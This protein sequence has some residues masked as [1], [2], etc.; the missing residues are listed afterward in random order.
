MNYRIPKTVILRMVESAG[1]FDL[2]P[3]STPEQDWTAVRALAAIGQGLP[4]WERARLYAE[5]ANVFDEF[6]RH[7]PALTEDVL[8]DTIAIELAQF[9]P[10]EEPKDKPRRTKDAAP[11]KGIRIKRSNDD[12]DIPF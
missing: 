1:V 12:D 8:F 6:N 3:D 9:S 7:M 10:P 2:T 11:K 5:V 4:I